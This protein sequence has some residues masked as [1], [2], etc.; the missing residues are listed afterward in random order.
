MHLYYILRTVVL[1]SALV[2]SS[3]LF[4]SESL[5][6]IEIWDEKNYR[7]FDFGSY[8]HLSEEEIQNNTSY[9]S[10]T[11]KDLPFVNATS[12]GGIGTRTSYFFRGSESRHIL[13]TL[14]GMKLN[15]PSSVDRQFD[16]SF[17]TNSFVRE[18]TIFRSP[19]S[20]LFGQ[21]ALGGMIDLRTPQGEDAPSSRIK[22]MGGS[23]GTFQL[24]LLNNWKA[25]KS[26]GSLGTNLLRSDGLSKLNQKRFKAK[27]RDKVEN[28]QFFSSSLHKI[29][30]NLATDFLLSFSENKQE[31]D[32]FIKD[33]S[34]ESSEIQHSLIQQKSTLSFSQRNKMSIRN[35]YSKFDRSINS[36]LE[37][38]NRFQGMLFQNEVNFKLHQKR[39]QNLAGLI[40]ESESLDV[41]DLNK[42]LDSY[43]I[44]TQYKYNLGRLDYQAGFRLDHHEI[45]KEFLS[46]TT[47][48]SIK[49]SENVI[50]LQ[51]SR[52]YKAPSLY[53]LYGPPFMGFIVGNSSLTPES[54]DS[55][56][57]SFLSKYL[58]VSLFENK[59]KNLITY[60][61][62][63]YLNQ[64]QFKA[65]GVEGLVRIIENS[66]RIQPHL[67]YTGYS[68]YDGPILRRPLL[69]Y[70]VD[71]L[72]SSDDKLEYGLNFKGVSARRDLNENGEVVKLNPYEVIDL[73][74]KVNLNEKIYGFKLMNFLNRE[75]EEIYGYNVMP[76]SFFVSLSFVFK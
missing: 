9:V 55:L 61:Q 7:S 30:D 34:E 22:L 72:Y 54:Q 50:R 6:E 28:A 47:G 35:G 21:D 51:Y 45:F 39:W 66:Y 36:N 69:G 49:L 32:S 38:S 15:D 53:Q 68:D 57:L 71:V 63:G 52:G 76:R 27:E 75:F 26:Q 25:Q 17:L 16:D 65:R 73:S 29:S 2:F 42:N 43:S 46:I 24:D 48:V 23:F 4:S 58:D 13:M 67:S 41:D 33:S 12:N 44:F 37:E 3:Q 60:S 62:A 31:I 70:G 19:K 74:L 59:F 64:G 18:M 40:H 8:Y 56:E 1:F 20:T 11:I 10:E 14:D 5:E